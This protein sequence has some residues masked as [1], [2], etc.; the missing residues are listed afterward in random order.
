MA[1]C[2]ALNQDRELYIAT[3]MKYL[4]LVMTNFSFLD[5][6]SYEEYGEVADRY[7]AVKI[8]VKIILI[9]IYMAPLKYQVQLRNSAESGLQH[10]P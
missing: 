1:M 9:C 7:E 10:F 6:E 2:E 4:I 3:Q 5:M 8:C